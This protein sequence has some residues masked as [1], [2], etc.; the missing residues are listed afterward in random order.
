MS[1]EGVAHPKASHAAWS[2]AA[3]SLQMRSALPE[4][5]PHTPSV[6]LPDT[7]PY[8]ALQD[9]TRLCVWQAADTH[10]LTGWNSERRWS[11]PSGEGCAARGTV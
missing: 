9:W 6:S 2:A 4:V 3:S 5:L 11:A 8:T 1:E 10:R 7:A